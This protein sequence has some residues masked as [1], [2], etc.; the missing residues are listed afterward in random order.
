[1]APLLQLVKLLLAPDLG[2]RIA[3]QNAAL[4]AAA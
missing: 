4:G 2:A 3:P 1:M